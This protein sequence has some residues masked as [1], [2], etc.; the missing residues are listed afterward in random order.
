[1]YVLYTQ[2]ALCFMTVIEMHSLWISEY[3][4][5]LKAYFSTFWL[6]FLEIRTFK[7]HNAGNNILRNFFSSVQ[8]KASLHKDEWNS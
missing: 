8:H 7:E 2:V 1:M 6:I 3:F 4:Y 5:N